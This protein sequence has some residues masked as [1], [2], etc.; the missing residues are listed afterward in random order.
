MQSVFKACFKLARSGAEHTAS[1][2]AKL[3][4]EARRETK[5]R[6]RQQQEQREER[7]ERRRERGYDFWETV[8]ADRRDEYVIPDMN[9]KTATRRRLAG[10]GTWKRMMKDGY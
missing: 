6:R 4:P 10:R 2:F 7:A 9:R 3:Q 5:Q 8:R 1:G